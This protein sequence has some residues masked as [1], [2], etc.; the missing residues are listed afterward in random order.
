MGYCL[1]D[2]DRQLAACVYR[3]ERN[4]RGVEYRDGLSSCFGEIGGS[5]LH[6]II[7]DVELIRKV[8]FSYVSSF[9]AYRLAYFK[10]TSYGPRTLKRFTE[11]LKVRLNE[12]QAKVVAGIE[13]ISKFI[14]SKQGR[15]NRT[16]T[17]DLKRWLDIEALINSISADM[18]LFIKCLDYVIAGRTHASD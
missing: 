15:Y 4:E 12:R 11:T 17:T 1:A 2:I 13:S 14:E 9:A 18:D 5:S 8:L 16:E 6:I 10:F 7:S 3:I